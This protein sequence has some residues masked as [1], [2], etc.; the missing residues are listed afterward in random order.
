MPTEALGVFPGQSHKRP[1]PKDLPH[2]SLGVQWAEPRAPG[3]R[4]AVQKL[5]WPYLECSL[6]ANLFT[7]SE[8]PRG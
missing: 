8:A 6:N 3:T 1:G 7:R 2:S 5:S 4:P